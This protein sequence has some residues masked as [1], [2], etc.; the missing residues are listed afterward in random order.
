M[1]HFTHNQFCPI[2][3]AADI[4]SKKWTLLVLRELHLGATSFG[5]MKKGLPGISPTVLSSRLRDLTHHGIITNTTHDVSSKNPRY[6]LTKS[7]IATAEILQQLGSWSQS[8]V[9]AER[10]LEHTNAGLL[11][12]DMARSIKTELMPEERPTIAV[13]FTDQP[14]NLSSWLLKS[15]PNG[16]MEASIGEQTKQEVDL[17]IRSTLEDMTAVWTGIEPLTNAIRHKRINLSGNRMLKASF[18]KWFGLSHFSNISKIA[19]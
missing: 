11:L 14:E 7:G 10:V 6:H 18:A 2:S 1:T 17:Y 8:H 3:L 5:Y 13:I 12:R 19:S 9:P 4:L 16:S 15:G